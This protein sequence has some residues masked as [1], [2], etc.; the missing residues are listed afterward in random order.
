MGGDREEGERGVTHDVPG[1]PQREVILLT[2]CDGWTDAC[3]SP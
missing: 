1:H 2:E 3:P